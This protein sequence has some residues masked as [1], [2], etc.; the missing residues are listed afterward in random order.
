M[1]QSLWLSY[2]DPTDFP[3]LADDLTVD[4]AIIGGGIT[5]VTTAQLLSEQGLRVAV[6]EKDRV[7]VNSTGR[8]TGNLYVAVSEILLYVRK[9]L[10]MK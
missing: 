2:S 4:V 5:G 10:G 9:N 8:S 6:I 3:I 1:N 7:G